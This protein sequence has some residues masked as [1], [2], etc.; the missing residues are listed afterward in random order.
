M[1]FAL[2]NRADGTTV[3]KESSANA[4]P[5]GAEFNIEFA[6]GR[7]VAFGPGT[8]DTNQTYIRLRDEDGDDRYIDVTDTTIAASATRP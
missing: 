6:D 7:Q 1:P 3:M 8:T 4:T 5:S 2:T